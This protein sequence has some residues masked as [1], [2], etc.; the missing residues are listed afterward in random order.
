MVDL[1]FLSVDVGVSHLAVLIP[2][3]EQ[4]GAFLKSGH[5]HV[6]QEASKGSLDSHKEEARAHVVRGRAHP[7]VP[8]LLKVLG[9]YYCQRGGPQSQHLDG[10]VIAVN[11]VSSVPSQ[12]AMQFRFLLY[13]NLAAHGC[14]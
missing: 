8:M 14:C 9:G 6:Q 3:E 1:R 13:R 5:C 12:R 4:S 11:I 7:D 2:A 10:N